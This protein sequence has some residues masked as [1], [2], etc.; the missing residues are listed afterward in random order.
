MRSFLFCFVFVVVIAGGGGG[1]GVFLFVCFVFVFFVVVL[2]SC[3]LF[4]RIRLRQREEGIFFF[5]LATQ[6]LHYF[7][8]KF[9]RYVLEPRNKL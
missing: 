4:E 1:G 8:E 5:Q 3:V 2:F 7:L 6:D 9:I